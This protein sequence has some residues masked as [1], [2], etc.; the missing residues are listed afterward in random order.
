M[1]TVEWKW[2]LPLVCGFCVGCGGSSSD[3]GPAIVDPPVTETMPAVSTQR[4]FEQ[5][6]FNQPLA[7]VQAPG[8]ASRWFVV[9]RAGYIR[10]FDNDP[11]ASAATTFL[12]IS[13]R[14]DSGANEAGLL[15]MAFHPDFPATAEVLVSYTRP[16][17]PLVSYIS[18]FFSTDNG[19]TLN[20]G[21]ED[22]ILT[23]LQSAGNH[24][25]GNLA[26]GPGGDLYIGFGDGGGSGDPGENAQDTNNLL[27]SIVRIDVDSAVPYAIPTGNAFTSTN[28]FCDQGFGSA[29]CPEIFAWGFRN[30]WR[31]S[32]DSLTDRLW[33]GDVGQSE[34]EEVDVVVARA[35][36]G[37]NDREGA[38]CFDPPSG[39]ANTFTDPMTEYDHSLGASITGGYVYHGAAI[40]DLVGWYVFADFISGRLFAVPEDS[41]VGVTAH[42]L[43]ATGLSIASFGEANDAELFVVHY[44]GTIHQ[45]IAAP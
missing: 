5:L 7:L 36:Y 26:F 38:H 11:N 25:G 14:V 15:G 33:V 4:V 32:F 37:W 17:S 9:E 24:N 2:M 28:A 35:N 43:S 20:A 22:V 21:V 42:E 41:P 6:S 13:A 16:G 31:F 30:P 18:R 3:P 1:R 8:D 10:A 44:A 34:W 29:P 39:C 40:P 45:I 27:G 12:D 23:V 19:L